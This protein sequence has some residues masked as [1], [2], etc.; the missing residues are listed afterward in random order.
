MAQI[1]ADEITRVLREEIE[2]YERAVSVW[3]PGSLF[4]S[5]TASPASTGLRRL[6][7][8]NSLNFRTMCRALH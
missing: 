1:R 3:K 2:N 7:P 8:A 6:W 5:A 4:R